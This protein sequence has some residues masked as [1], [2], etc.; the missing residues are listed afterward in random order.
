MNDR[1]VA[2]NATYTTYNKHNR[3]TSMPSAGMELATIAN[4]RLQT[5]TFDGRPLRSVES[6]TVGIYV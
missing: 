6:F 1:L 2:E 4:K 5:Y 3:R